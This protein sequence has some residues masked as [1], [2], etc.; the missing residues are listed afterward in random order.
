[1]ITKRLLLT[2]LMGVS[3][4]ASAQ[5]PAVTSWIINTT[6]LTGYNCS[7]CTPAHNGTIPANIQSVYYTSTDVY[8]KG[9]S[10]PSYNIGPWTGN[11]NTPSDQNATFKIT[12]NP[13]PNT[14]TLVTVPMGRVGVWSNGVTIYNPRDGYYW[15]SAA[16]AFGNSPG[17]TASW[18]RNAYVFEAV[19]FDACLG[20]PDQSG[21]YHNHVNPK[22]IYD[23]SAST[24]HSPIIGYSFDGYPVY[25]AY[26]YTNTD[27]TGAIKRMK[28]SYVLTTNTTRAGGPPMSAY[29]AGNFCEDYVYTPGAGDLDAHNGRTC[30]TPEYP[31]GT[32][33]YFVTIDAS[34]IPQ[35]PFVLGPTYY[36]TVQTGNTGMMGGHNTV[37]TGATQYV[38]HSTGVAETE[39]NGDEITIYPN[40]ALNNT[41]KFHAE[42]NTA[43]LSISIIDFQGRV[44]IHREYAAGTYGAEISVAAPYLSTGMYMVAIESN[45]SKMVKRVLLSED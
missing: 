27:G 33:A 37:P 42:H 7:G 24:V 43:A 9:A 15:D 25:G 41:F 8:V 18:N 5:G 28:S 26:A 14:G 1:M 32:Y 35:Y 44:L 21:S 23:A 34:G 40:P 39:A 20:H 38:P 12:L 36:G 16:G 30:K 3:L 17:V 22:C 13:T 29:P 31:G 11:P 45:G 19:S 2:A 10:I 4:A 6:G